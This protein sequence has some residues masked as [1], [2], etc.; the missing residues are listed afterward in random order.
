MNDIQLIN[1]MLEWEEKLNQDKNRS[2]NPFKEYYVN[3][4]APVRQ[5]LK[6]C[7]AK[8]EDSDPEINPTSPTAG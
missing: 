5:M 4:L 6:N 3:Y 7:C 2:G 1:T 8:T